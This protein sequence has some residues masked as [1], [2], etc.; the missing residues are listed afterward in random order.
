[1]NGKGSPVQS[2]FLNRRTERL[3]NRQKNAHNTLY[4]LHMQDA[5]DKKYLSVLPGFIKLQKI[6]GLANNDKV[7]IKHITVYSPNHAIST[8][9]AH[10]YSTALIFD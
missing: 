10:N 9:R 5:W 1:M 2:S 7:K 3:L 6:F 4:V 8:Y